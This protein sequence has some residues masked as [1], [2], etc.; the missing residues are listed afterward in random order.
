[1]TV[2]LTV[3]LFV[4]VCRVKVTSQK[5]AS[6]VSVA[7]NVIPCAE[8]ATEENCTEENCKTYTLLAGS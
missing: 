4:C 3:C 6:V 7:R 1:M 2:F 8:I 5:A